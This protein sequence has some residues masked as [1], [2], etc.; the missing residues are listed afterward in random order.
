MCPK[1]FR[2]PA[3]LQHV[4][5]SLKKVRNGKGLQSPSTCREAQDPE[6]ATASQKQCTGSVW[7][8][9]TGTGCVKCGTHRSLLWAPPLSER[10]TARRQRVLQSQH[11]PRPRD[12]VG[13]CCCVCRALLHKLQAAPSSRTDLITPGE[14]QVQGMRST[15]PGN[16]IAGCSRAGAQLFPDVRQGPGRGWRQTPS[17][18]SPSDVL[19]SGG[20]GNQGFLREGAAHRPR[21]SQAPPCSSEDQSRASL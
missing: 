11:R 10:T 6:V 13:G 21:E 16:R 15:F 17:L 20:R 12:T 5:R 18:R 14:F 4:T 1:G 19:G 3:G 8:Q 2:G 7:T 9:G